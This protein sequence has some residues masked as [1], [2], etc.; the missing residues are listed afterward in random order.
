MDI[1]YYD[2][3]KEARGAVFQSIVIRDN[4]RIYHSRAIYNFLDLLG[5]LGGIVEIVS[6]VL[7]LFLFQISYHSYITKAI[8]RLFFINSKEDYF[9]AY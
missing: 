7:G 6:I 1:S 2:L 9:K 8:S 5:D 3:M 4:Q